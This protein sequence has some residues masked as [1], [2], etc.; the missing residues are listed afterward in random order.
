MGTSR[1][2]IC[3]PGLFG[4]R[5]RA[6][7]LPSNAVPV[8]ISLSRKTTFN[9]PLLRKKPPGLFLPSVQYPRA[10]KFS[11]AVKKGN[12][13]RKI[14][15]NAPKEMSSVQTYVPNR[16]ASRDA[17]LKQCCPVIVGQKGQAV[18]RVAHEALSLFFPPKK[19]NAGDGR[20]WLLSAHVPAPTLSAFSISSS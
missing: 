7:E 1:S 5:P 6:Q 12:R 15:R 14:K 4:L 8:P 18:A 2:G 3:R 17:G 11:D 9:K 19:K 10:P 16:G 20:K 13:R